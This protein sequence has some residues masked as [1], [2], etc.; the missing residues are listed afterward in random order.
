MTS[1]FL[2]RAI[3]QGSGKSEADL[4]IKGG[5]LFDLVTGELTVTDIAICGDRIVGSFGDY[6]GRRQI[7]ARG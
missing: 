3:D 4:V 2:A 1:E 5:R 7:E 6:R